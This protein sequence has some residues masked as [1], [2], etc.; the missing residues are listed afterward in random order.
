M[1]SACVPQMRAEVTRDLALR[2]GPTARPAPSAQLAAPSAAVLTSSLG[3]VSI[4]ETLMLRG[5]PAFDANHLDSAVR[6]W[7][8]ELWDTLSDARFVAASTDLARSDDLYLYG[9]TL[10]TTINAILTAFRVTGDLALLDEVDRLAEHM[11]SQLRDGWRGTRDGTSGTRDGYLNW[12]HRTSGASHYGK[13]LHV[14]DE[15]RTHALVA[16]FTWA[17]HANRDLTSPS[18]VP[19]GE[20]ADLW[21][22]YLTEHFEAKWR[23]RNNVTG[24]AFPFLEHDSL[25]SNVAFTK[26][27]HYMG[28]MLSSDR[29]RD[30][31]ER[32]SRRVQGHF[33][34][35]TVEGE[36]ALV[37]PRRLEVQGEQHYLQPAT[38]ARY[39]LMDAVTLHLEGARAW[40][41]P[42]LVAALA[43]TVRELI[44]DR[45]ADEVAFHRDVGGGV[46]RGGIPATLASD[47]EPIT[48]ER[49]AD[50]SYA[51]VARWDRTG[52]IASWS[53]EVH[54]RL[55]LNATGVHLPVAMLLALAS[56]RRVETTTR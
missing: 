1:A 2:D 25:H 34:A 17:F 23:K 47:Y 45:D 28:R 46:A 21:R 26:F 6:F 15:M 53:L 49:F 10:H 5:D 37:W 56:D 16:E 39:V 12:V 14:F 8:D 20:R 44:M 51:F 13:D 3:P 29:H 55:D 43:V 54:E 30:E 4:S 31:S 22:T 35:I 7:Y 11:R 48:V 36:R 19:Y 52:T 33:V 50:S 38:Y 41:D 24:S 27:H 18:G 9:R 42:S 40:S 32:L